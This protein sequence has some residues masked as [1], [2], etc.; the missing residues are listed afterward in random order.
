MDPTKPETILANDFDARLEQKLE[1]LKEVPLDKS[2]YTGEL[3]CLEKYQSETVCVSS[4]EC[5]L[6]P[7]LE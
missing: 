3:G 1:Q 5:E 6:I 2:W 4:H 7:P